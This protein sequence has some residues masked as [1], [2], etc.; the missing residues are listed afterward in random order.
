[1]DTPSKGNIPLTEVKSQCPY[2][3]R[4]RVRMKR[5]KVVKSQG[6][7]YMSA[8]RLLRKLAEWLLGMKFHKIRMI[9]S[10]SHNYTIIRNI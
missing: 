4:K 7:I 5:D 6:S 2:F 8:T 1:M 10:D 3:L 9:L